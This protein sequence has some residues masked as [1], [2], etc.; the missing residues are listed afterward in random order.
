MAAYIVQVDC[1][2]NIASNVWNLYLLSSNFSSGNTEQ[3]CH[4]NFSA[5]LQ[6]IR[7]KH[8]GQIILKLVTEPDGYNLLLA[9]SVL[10]I[11]GVDRNV[12]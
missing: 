10:A 5:I 4:L 6:N 9:K 12:Q 3:L 11:Q 8:Q 7:L 1:F 2:L